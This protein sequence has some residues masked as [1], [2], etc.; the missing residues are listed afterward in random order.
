M[1][2]A[3]NEFEATDPIERALELAVRFGGIDGSHHKAWVI[4]QMVRVLTGHKYEEFVREACDDERR[5][6]HRSRNAQM[7]PRVGARSS[8]HRKRHGVRDRSVGR[9]SNHDVPEVRIGGVG[10]HRLR[11]LLGGEPADA[12]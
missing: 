6:S 12:R 10:E 7:R 1:S 11:P 3:F 2:Q 4:D 5:R 9:A 8:A